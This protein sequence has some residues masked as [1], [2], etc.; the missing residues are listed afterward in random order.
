MIFN[1]LI[2]RPSE[3]RREGPKSGK[4]EM[5]PAVKLRCAV[6]D[7]GAVSSSAVTHALRQTHA[8]DSHGR[9][10]RHR[11]DLEFDTIGQLVAQVEI[12][13]IRRML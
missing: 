6:R 9:N 5:D 11:R 10:D 3:C 7:V 13:A 2:E 4:V 12:E 1:W 8:M